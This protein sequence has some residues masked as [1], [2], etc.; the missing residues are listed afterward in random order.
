MINTTILFLVKLW[1]GWVNE[2]KV[3]RQSVRPSVRRALDVEIEPQQMTNMRARP[4]IYVSQNPEFDKI[5]AR[6]ERD[7]NMHN[8]FCLVVGKTK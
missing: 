4:E 7:Q 3:T 6:R 8:F 2:V 1:M 5:D